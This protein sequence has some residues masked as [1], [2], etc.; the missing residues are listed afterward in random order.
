MNENTKNSVSARTTE[1][2]YEVRK[3]GIIMTGFP[4]RE[5]KLCAING[6]PGKIF[7]AEGRDVTDQHIHR[8]YGKLMIT[9]ADNEILLTRGEDALPGCITADFALSV[10]KPEGAKA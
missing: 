9:L 7:D 1:P 10:E 3:P 8:I 2:L 4:L 6:A 5:A